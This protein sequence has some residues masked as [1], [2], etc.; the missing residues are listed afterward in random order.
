MIAAL[1]LAQAAALAVVAAG[2]GFGAIGA[3]LAV[4]G[5]C[6]VPQLSLFLQ[7]PRV[8]CIEV[9]VPVLAEPPHQTEHERTRKHIAGSSKQEAES[10]AS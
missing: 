7:Q 5:L 1:C 9:V 10:K 6:A 2:P 4:A 8:P 3:A